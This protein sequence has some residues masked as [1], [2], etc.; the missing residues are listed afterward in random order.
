[1]QEMRIGNV[2]VARLAGLS[3]TFLSWGCD[4]TG[5]GRVL[6]RRSSL[7]DTNRARYVAS[8]AYF[9]VLL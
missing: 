5:C 2:G 1:M 4:V 7:S 8:N 3:D 9:G 6:T